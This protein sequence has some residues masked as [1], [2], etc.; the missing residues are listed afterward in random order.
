VTPAP[1]ETALDAHGHRRP[2]SRTDAPQIRQAI[3]EALATGSYRESA[4]R[5][6]REMASA[7]SI[8][9]ILEDLLRAR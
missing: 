4:Q 1:V 9:A 3:E 8:D 6:A 5:I 2:P 7:P